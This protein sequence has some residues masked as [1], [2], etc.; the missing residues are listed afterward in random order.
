MGQ[1]KQYPEQLFITENQIF[2]PKQFTDK[3]VEEELIVYK[4]IFISS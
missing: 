4:K 3:P 1:L 2:F